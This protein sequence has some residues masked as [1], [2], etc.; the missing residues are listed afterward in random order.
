MIKG[1]VLVE[2]MLAAA[3]VSLALVALLPTFILSIKASK[4]SEQTK[5]AA[6]LAIELLEE[7][8]L[9]RWDELTPIPSAAIA[10]GSAA[11]GVDTGENAADKRTFNDVDDFNGWTE[12]LPQDPM[13]QPLADFAGYRRSA[14]VQYVNSTLSPSASPTDYK[15]VS[16]CVRTPKGSSICLNTLFTNR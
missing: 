11:I 5:V 7:I 14:T 16:V 13:M 15:Q 1:F 4:R 6:Q 2:S 12:N 3:L 8:R 10:Q 9:R